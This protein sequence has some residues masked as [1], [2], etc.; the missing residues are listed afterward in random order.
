MDFSNVIVSSIC[1]SVTSFLQDLR[2]GPSGDGSRKPVP[3]FSS[4]DNGRRIDAQ[5]VGCSNGGQTVDTDTGLGVDIEDLRLAVEL[6]HRVA[7]CVV[8]V[9]ETVQP[10]AEDENVAGLGYVQSPSGG[11]IGVERRVLPPREGGEEGAG[12]RW[13]GLVVWGFGLRKTEVVVRGAGEVI[14][15]DNVVLGPGADEPNGTLRFRQETPT[16]VDGYLVGVQGL[17][18]VIGEPDPGSFEVRAGVAG[19]VDG[20]KCGKTLA[21]ANTGLWAL[22]DLELGSSGTS[23]TNIGIPQSSTALGL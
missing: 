9:E 4:G 12:G 8:V 20:Q 23:E 16:G 17:E 3:V 13:I 5:L 21:V 6:I 7:L 22:S 15:D 10:S 14:V 11:L 18:V 1:V 2:R 19:Q